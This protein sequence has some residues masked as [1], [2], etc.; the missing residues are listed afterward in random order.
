[1]TNIFALIL[2]VVVVTTF[3]V[4][5]YK[6][7]KIEERV[8]TLQKGID[9]CYAAFTDII[10]VLSKAVDAAKATQQHKEQPNGAEETN[11]KE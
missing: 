7:I 11:N 2:V 9:L 6:T 10:E 3:A 4:S 1:M 5:S 8:D